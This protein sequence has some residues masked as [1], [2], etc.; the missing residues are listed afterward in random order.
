MRNKFIDL[1]TTIMETKIDA[2]FP[3]ARFPL[4]GYHTPYRLDTN[5]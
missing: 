1:Q 2:S 3:S 4:E 5:K